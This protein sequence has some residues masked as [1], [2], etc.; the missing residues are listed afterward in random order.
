MADL[1]ALIFDVDG[2]LADTER[3]GHRV[4]FNQAFADA[5]LEWEWSV[6]LYGELLAVTGGKE[7]I[8]HFI[9]RHSPSFQSPGPVDQFI[10]D[11]HSRK[12]DHYLRLLR[13]GKIPLR[14]GVARL[15]R[16]V[17]D[18]SI[19]LAIA[20]T[21]T[22]ANVVYLLEASLGRESIE[23]FSVI[24]AGDVVPAKKPAPDIF[25]Y[26]L[27]HLA[28]GPEQCLAF[29]DSENGLRATSAAGLRT[30]ITI[31]DYTRHQDFSGAALVLDQLCDPNH[32]L[33]LLQGSVDGGTHIDIGLILS[34]FG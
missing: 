33:Q 28:L 12:T 32:P 23:W 30:V 1:K 8:R 14:P 25:H 21:T 9:E 24:A 5:G 16:E 2:T 26:A 20:T 7:R 6:P 31:N 15:L 4:A 19:T 13:E 29:E 34:L 22:P 27:T 18:A 3:D 10:A 11:L 17:R